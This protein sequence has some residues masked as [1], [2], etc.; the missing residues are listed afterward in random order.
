MERM[1]Q[2]RGRNQKLDHHVFIHIT[3][4]E[5]EVTVTCKTLKTA[6]TDTVHCLFLKQSHQV[7]TEYS[8]T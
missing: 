4:T 5:Q 3:E 6:L 2:A 8:N 1:P 7:E